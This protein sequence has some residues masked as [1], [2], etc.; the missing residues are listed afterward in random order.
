[1][2]PSLRRT[3]AT[4]GQT[5]CQS[6]QCAACAG[7]RQHTPESDAIIH[8]IHR[9]LTCCQKID[10]AILDR[11]DTFSRRLDHLDPISQSL[12]FEVLSC[13]LD[14]SR[15]GI[16]CDYALEWRK[17]YC[18]LSWIFWA[19]FV[20]AISEVDVLNSPVPHPRSSAVSHLALG[21]RP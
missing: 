13:L 3:R 2:V 10:A 17:F 19:S 11:S 12:R 1:M 4:S 20:S 6:N 21:I 15:S 8:R 14:H 5:F 9:S 18:S 16:H 7:R